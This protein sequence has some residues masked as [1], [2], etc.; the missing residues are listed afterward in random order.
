MFYEQYKSA[1]NK[2]KQAC[3]QHGVSNTMEEVF[4]EPVLS[5]KLSMFLEKFPWKRFP[6]NMVL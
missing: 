3:F 5:R 2:T 4:F 6:W 1:S